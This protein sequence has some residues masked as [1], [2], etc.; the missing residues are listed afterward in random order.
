[1]NIIQKILHTNKSLES[2]RLII[3][4]IKIDSKVLKDLFEIY[5]DSEN[6]ENYCE[7][8]TNFDFFSG[9][10]TEK[11]MLH[12]EKIGGIVSFLIKH[13]KDNKYIGV[14]NMILDGAYTYDNQ[15]KDNNNNLISEIL[16][17]KK[18]WNNNYA[19][20]ASNIIF[21]YLK[22]CGVK[23]IATFIEKS[24]AKAKKLSVKLNFSTINKNE[25]FL[26]YNF[27]PHSEMHTTNNIESVQITIKKL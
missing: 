16:I 11:I 25:L 23:N 24:N 18:Y 1:M 5:S 6:V 12:Q 20:E 14:R 2:K 3:N 10:M 13:K 17:N 4:P 8:Y 26:K 21:E 15:R 22:E 19:E 27:H 7:P 9:Y